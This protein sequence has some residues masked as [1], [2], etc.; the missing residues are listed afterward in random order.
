MWQVQVT[1]EKICA[2][3]CNVEYHV[4]NL[5]WAI[6][7]EQ[8]CV[9]HNIFLISIIMGRELG[10]TAPTFY[11]FSIR[12]RFSPYKL[13]LC[14]P[15]NLIAFLCPSWLWTHHVKPLMTIMDTN[16][17][18]LNPFHI[19]IQHIR[20]CHVMSCDIM[21]CS[22]LS[23][24]VDWDDVTAVAVAITVNTPLLG[25]TMRHIITMATW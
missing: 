9:L 15:L 21:W 18:A 7:C 22:L 20:L 11:I 6:S 17:I 12:I 25:T 8:S 4:S 2:V 23:L 14:G 24:T 1:K 5:M 13:I 3:T 10:G 19:I 16:T